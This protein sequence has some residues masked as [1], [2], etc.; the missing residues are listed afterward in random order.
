MLAKA[1]PYLGLESC[2]RRL[3]VREVVTAVGWHQLEQV[4]RRLFSLVF[5]GRDVFTDGSLVPYGGP[6]AFVGSAVAETEA[7]LGL[8]W[9]SS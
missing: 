6:A 2:R 4:T 1:L 5:A 8:E 3:R 9:L 7:R